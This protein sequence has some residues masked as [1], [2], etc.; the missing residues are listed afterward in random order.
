MKVKESY[1]WIE[2]DMKPCQ[3]SLIVHH[4][5]LHT[6]EQRSNQ[7]FPNMTWRKRVMHVWLKHRRRRTTTKEALSRI[8]SLCTYQREK[9]NNKK[10]T[11]LI[12]SDNP[13]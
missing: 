13:S 7:P 6:S 4:C 5:F 3:S 11:F 2:E 9:K 12:K 10:N 8:Q 1:T